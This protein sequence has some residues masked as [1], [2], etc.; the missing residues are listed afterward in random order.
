MR[1]LLALILI[2]IG[3]ATGFFVLP[4]IMGGTGIGDLTDKLQGG[5]ED[6]VVEKLTDIAEISTVE[7]DYKNAV[8]LNSDKT[9][10][11]S[12]KVPFSS[13]KVVM[14]YDGKIK[15]GANLKDLAVNVEKD[16]AGNVESVKVKLPKMKI[17]SHE[18]DR[19]SIK[20]PIEESTIINKI[21][22]KDYDELEAK[23]KKEIAKIAKSSD[24]MDTA[25]KQLKESMT[26]YVKGLYGKDVK[27]V[28][29]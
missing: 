8:K 7:Y 27:V 24:A 11:D 23:G 10:F 29:E 15:I 16:A 22:N 14:I 6:A 25:E 19:D 18:M 28:F 12:I 5:D 26:G 17:T 21:S 4:S 1:R 3:L 20:F 9:L 2:L 13:K